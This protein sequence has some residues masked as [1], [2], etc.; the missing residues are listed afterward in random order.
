MSFFAKIKHYGLVFLDKVSAL[1]VIYL[2]FTNPAAA[3]AASKAKELAKEKILEKRE[4]SDA[5]E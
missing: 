3:V 2:Q 4:S 1:G 5:S